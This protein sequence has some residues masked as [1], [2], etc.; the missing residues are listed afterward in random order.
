MRKE[1][2][3]TRDFTI[4][5]LGQIIS[6]FGNSMLR[7]ALPLFL[8]RETNSSSL[9]G[10][11]TACAF[12]PAV[13]F[14]L[15]GGVIADRVNKRNI[16]VFLDLCTAAIT[17]GFYLSLG[18][19]P[20]AHATAITLM[21][22]YGISGAYEPAVQASIPLLVTGDR[23]M[24]GNAVIN[25]VNTLSNLLGP[26]IG[27]LLY[28]IFG[29]GP[30]LTCCALCFAASGLMEVFLHIPH[31]KRESLP[32][33]WVTARDD[34]RKSFHFLRIEKPV[35]LQVLGLLAA[36]NLVLSAAMVVGIPIIVVELLQ[37]PDAFL[38]LAQG[39]LGLGGLLGGMLAGTLGKKIRPGQG[40]IFLLIC[41]ASVLVMGLALIPAFP[42]KLSFWVLTAMCI[43]AMAAATMFTVSMSTLVQRQCPEHLLGKVMA[44]IIAVA[45][46]S[47]PIGQAIYGFLFEFLA[48]CPWLILTIAALTAF[49]I[50]LHA[51]QI[52]LKLE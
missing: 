41:S 16:M 7:F 30:I 19:L 12:V 10:L 31:H 48:A 42:A 15:V 36:F 18:S 1:S 20:L 45:S 28:G 44:S 47:Q 33:M 24:A 3:F 6:L 46:C 13:L 52:F 21:L 14:S 26:V 22:L 39:G 8:L 49:G 4:V 17:V 51:R 37:M 34:L 43:A 5:V 35:F 29:L 9:F 2:L 38:G 40:S 50:S 32:G 25:A 11:I 27:G 23:L